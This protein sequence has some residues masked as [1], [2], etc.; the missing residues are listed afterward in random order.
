MQYYLSD[1]IRYNGGIIVKQVNIET[2]RSSVLRVKHRKRDLSGKIQIYLMIGIPFLLFAVFVIY[3]LLW[4][5][6]YAFYD[7]D[8]VKAVY[9]GLQNFHI[10]MKDAIWWKAVGNTILMTLG[11]I[12]LGMPP[13]LIL[14]I[15]LNSKFKGKIASKIILYVPCLISTSIVGVIFQIMLSPTDGIINQILLSAHIIKE[16]IYILA[17]EGI[18]MFTIILVGIWQWTGYNMTLFLAGLQKIPKEIYEAAIIDGANERQ[19]IVYITVPQ[20]GNMLKVILMLSLINGL[21]QFDLVSVLTNGHP[22]HGTTT[23]VT[24]IYNY[25]FEVEGYRAQQG[26]AA[27]ASVVATII[28]TVVTLIYFVISKRIQED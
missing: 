16:P 25:F 22:N 9:T 10:L 24:Y 6:R 23:I 3:P 12:I 27:A 21:K 5:L 15:L 14:A 18:A 28:I 1:I 26:Y 7:Y 8:G 11:S 4:V 20:L 2:V 19:K 17:N 13:A